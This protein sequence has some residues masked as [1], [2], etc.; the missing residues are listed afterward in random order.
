VV[1]VTA[2]RLADDVT[3]GDMWACSARERASSLATS[4][5]CVLASVMAML[6]APWHPAVPD[7]SSR[8]LSVSAAL[9]WTWIVAQV[10]ALPSWTTT[11]VLPRQIALLRRR[12]CRRFG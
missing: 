1:V 7:V 11:R 8:R 9:K 2:D 6:D 3:E 10:F 4:A 5:A 12:C